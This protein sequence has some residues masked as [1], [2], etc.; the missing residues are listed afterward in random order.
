MRALEEDEA[1]DERL[2]RDSCFQL[3]VFSLQ[4]FVRNLGACCATLFAG[5]P[6]EKRAP[7]FFAPERLMNGLTHALDQQHLIG[8]IDFVELD[9]DNFAATCGHCFANIRGL[10]RQLAMA[11]VNQHGKLNAART[12]VVE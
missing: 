6:Q 3:S 1:G 9:F 8:L 5:K 7:N 10:D 11:A 12:T 4:L 2:L